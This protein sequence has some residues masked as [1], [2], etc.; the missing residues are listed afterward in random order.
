MPTR[1]HGD[2]HDGPRGKPGYERRRS[3]RSDAR[4]MSIDGGAD[5]HPAA[6]SSRRYYGVGVPGSSLLTGAL[7]ACRVRMPVLP[8]RYTAAVP[9]EVTSA[10]MGME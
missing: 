2:L 8:A 6:A 10:S 3:A 9:R 1:N 5:A 4:A 7:A